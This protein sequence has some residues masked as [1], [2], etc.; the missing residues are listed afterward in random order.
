[1]R[2]KL[3]TIYAT[4]CMLLMA[5]GFVLVFVFASKQ[6]TWQMIEGLYGLAIGFII[7]PIFHELGHVV[8][9]RMANMEEVYVKCFCFA[10]TK[11]Q[12]KWKISFRSPMAPDETQVIPKSGGDMQ[13]RAKQYAIGGLVFGGVLFV[14]LLVGA[15]LCTVLGVTQYALWGMIPYPAYLFF[16]NLPPVEYPLGKTD[17]L[18][19]QGLKKGEDA[20]KVMIAIMEIQGQLY[21]GKSYTEIEESLY[22]HLPQLRMDEPL[23]VALLDLR[24]RYFLEKEEYERAGDCL[25]RMLA[26]RGY[27]SE[28]EE[29]KVLAECTYLHI[30]RGNLTEAEACSKGCRNYLQAEDVSAKRIL[31]AFAK[32]FGQEHAIEPLRVQAEEALEKEWIAGVKKAETKLLAKI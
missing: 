22:F 8:F 28:W 5:A 21:E 1:M 10:F 23:Y 18:V 4:L 11:E 26:A 17:A 20:E 31:L 15:L 30:L 19:Y 13:R 3:T 16:L 9:A 6:G 32:T 24:Y 29:E 14:V 12:G 27:L 25:Q 2:R 7:A